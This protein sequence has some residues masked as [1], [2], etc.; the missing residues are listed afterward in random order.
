MQINF[1]KAFEDW[2]KGSNDKMILEYL[3]S[4]IKAALLGT[5]FFLALSKEDKEDAIQN[6]F[7]ITL[8]ALNK[9][10]GNNYRGINAYLTR[11]ITGAIL[12][13][14][15][16][17]LKKTKPTVTSESPELLETNTFDTGL[18]VPIGKKSI[19]DVTEMLIQQYSKVEIMEK[20]GLSQSQLQSIIEEI[21]L[22]YELTPR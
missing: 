21:K 4:R 12:D 5:N 18:I 6:V 16:T 11:T 1:D 22:I 7:F 8:K 19:D 13:L 20:L 10:E 2:K 17:Y 9:A 15:K 14:K 3:E